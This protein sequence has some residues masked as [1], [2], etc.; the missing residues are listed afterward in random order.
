M[1]DTEIIDSSKTHYGY[2]A[3]WIPGKKICDHV[4]THNHTVYSNMLLKASS[5][6]SQ[7]IAVH[8]NTRDTSNCTS[9][10]FTSLPSCLSISSL[11]LCVVW[12]H[13]LLSDTRHHLAA[14]TTGK[15]YQ[16]THSQYIWISRNVLTLLMLTVELLDGKTSLIVYFHQRGFQVRLH[17]W[18]C[19]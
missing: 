6:T 18:P 3:T 4:H 17:I 14:A 15:H 12:T 11:R 16:Y 13:R 19:K 10:D 5:F 9:K 1:L 8:S 7:T 2:H